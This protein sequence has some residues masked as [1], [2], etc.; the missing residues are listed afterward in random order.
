MP[1]KAILESCKQM[2]SSDPIKIGKY[3]GFDMELQLNL[4]THFYE[5]LLKSATT[6]KSIAR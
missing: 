1:E 5:V 4:T 3:R 6:Q 2:N